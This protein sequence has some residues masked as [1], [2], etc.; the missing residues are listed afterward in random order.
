MIA[1]LCLTIGCYD[2]AVE[3]GGMVH[4]VVVVV[5]HWKVHK[6]DENFTRVKMGYFCY[7]ESLAHLVSLLEITLRVL[8]FWHL[9]S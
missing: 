4:M 9:F 6:N 3:T 7:H 8:G 1:H 5:G 2:A